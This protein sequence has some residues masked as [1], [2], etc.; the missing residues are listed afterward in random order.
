MFITFMMEEGIGIKPI[1]P[2]NNS[3]ALSI[4]RAY[5]CY[6]FL[7]SDKLLSIA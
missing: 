4:K 7:M 3:G 2:E 5:Q 6:D 1:S